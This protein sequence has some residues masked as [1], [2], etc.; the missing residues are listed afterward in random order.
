MVPVF[1]TLGI[2]KNESSEIAMTESLSNTKPFVPGNFLISPPLQAT[3]L[4]P[5]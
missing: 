5:A 4:P 2:A 1:F 3:T